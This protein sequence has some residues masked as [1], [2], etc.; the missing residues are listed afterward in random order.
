[1]LIGGG[2]RVVES[3]DMSATLPLPGKGGMIRPGMAKS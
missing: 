2:G 1:M 3:E